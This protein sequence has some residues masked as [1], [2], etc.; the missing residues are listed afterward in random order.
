[1]LD[2]PKAQLTLLKTLRLSG[3]KMPLNGVY[4]AV[5]GLTVTGSEHRIAPLLTGPRVLSRACCLF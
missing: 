3:E 1:M 2:A 4:L 5:G